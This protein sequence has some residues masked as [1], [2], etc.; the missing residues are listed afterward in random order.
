MPKL[1]D[2][3]RCPHCGAQLPEPKPRMCPVCAGSLQVRFLKYGCLSS[4]PKLIALAV[5]LWWL[6]RAFA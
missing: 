2:E 5:G 6:C 3:R 1:I 4:A